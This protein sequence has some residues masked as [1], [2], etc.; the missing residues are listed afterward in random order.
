MTDAPQRVYVYL[1]DLPKF[2]SGMRGVIVETLGTKW[3][4]LRHP[5]YTNRVTRISREQWVQILI[6]TEKMHQRASGLKPI[7]VKR[8]I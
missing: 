4:R 5:V 2:G 8:R 3:V 1:V 7:K 6:D